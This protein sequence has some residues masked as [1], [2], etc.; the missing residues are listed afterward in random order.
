MCV[1]NKVILHIANDYTGSKVY[2]NLINELDNLYIEQIIYTPLRQKHKV[3][4][5]Q[6][7]F[8]VYNS[9]IIYSP[10]LNWHIDRFFY[11]YKIIK[12]LK[13]IESKVDFNHIKCIHAHTWYSD[14]GVAY[15]LS[16]KYK[17][18]Y[19]VTIRNTDLNLFQ[20][21][22][23]Y[24]RPF[25]K[26]ILNDAKKIILISASY[27]Q[28]ILNQNSLKSVKYK[29]EEKI[30]VIPNGVDYFWIQN[31]SA[32]KN[33]NK[34]KN[35]IFNILYIGKFS[36]GKQVPLL[37]E[38]IIQLNTRTPYKIILHIV[39][40]GGED[41]TFVLDMVKKHPKIFSYYGQIF[42]KSELL[43]IIRDCDIFAMPSQHETF[44]LV[45]IE[46][47]LQGLPILYTANEGIDGFYKD[48]IGE[49]INESTT[50]EI[51]QKIS[52]IINNYNKYIIPL[53]EMTEN[54]NW[55]KIA[56]RY[57]DNYYKL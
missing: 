17:I 18:P 30:E 21:K 52:K 11:P 10:I 31:S 7:N 40:K 51:V 37:Q 49:K 27:K 6:I 5:N 28:R 48:N 16:K 56:K 54:H 22:I 8:K 46:A 26:K 24:L 9:K 19:I 47:M 33:K 45:Y 42:N 41:E 57:I 34:N 55:I 1:Q 4:I 13:D 38:A 32:N 29:I 14:G 53:K 43:N 2:K 35:N 3:G 20:K 23:V 50:E 36:K 39:G 15:F 25:G 12:I 44:G